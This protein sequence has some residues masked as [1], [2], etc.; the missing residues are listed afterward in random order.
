MLL[1]LVGG[2]TPSQVWGRGVPQPGLDGGGYPIPGGIP[3]SDLDGSG[4]PHQRVGGVPQPGHDGGGYPIPGLGVPHPRG[5]PQPGLDGGGT[6][7]T[8]HHLDLARGYLGYPPPSRH[9]GGTPGT[10]P[11]SKPGQSTPTLWDGIP[12]TIQTWLGYPHPWDGV[13]PPQ[14]WDGVPPHLR[15]EMG[16]PPP[17][18]PDLDGVPPTSDL[19]W[20]TSPSKC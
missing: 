12:L 9:G 5:V 10:P 14:T 3:Q 18:H 7:G 8:P 2:G 16:Y 20:G 1:C 11:P 17:H 6:L 4:V 19:G 15:P 13:P